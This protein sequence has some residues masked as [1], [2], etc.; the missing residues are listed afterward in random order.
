M[1]M[2]GTV[3]QKNIVTRKKNTET[4]RIAPWHKRIKQHRT[5]KIPIQTRSTNCQIVQKKTTFYTVLPSQYTVWTKCLYTHSLHHT[6]SIQPHHRASLQPQQSL[7]ILWP[8]SWRLLSSGMWRRMFCCKS[9]DVS[10][11]LPVPRLIW[12][13]FWS[14]QNRSEVWPP[15]VR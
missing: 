10:A 8:V 14:Q 1:T 9:A 4:Q 2:N 7:T 13:I 3:K 12:I 5:H 15:L 6:A 11:E